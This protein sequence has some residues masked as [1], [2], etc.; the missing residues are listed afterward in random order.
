MYI[1]PRCWSMGHPNRKFQCKGWVRGSHP[2]KCAMLF[3]K[4]RPHDNQ[5]KILLLT[6]ALQLL[7]P[8]FAMLELHFLKNRSLSIHIEL[9]HVV[10][11]VS[12]LRSDLK[13]EHKVIW[14]LFLQ[15]QIATSK[16]WMGQI[17]PLRLF[18]HCPLYKQFK[19]AAS[20]MFLKKLQSCDSKLGQLSP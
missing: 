2:G 16:Y 19:R 20:E 10:S 4:A 9:C 1:T 14:I 18:F 8:G 5:N 12:V 3:I 15:Y 6:F 7:W 11:G 17:T 13:P